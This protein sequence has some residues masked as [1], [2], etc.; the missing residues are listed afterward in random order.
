MLKELLKEK[1]IGEDDERRGE[2]QIQ[3]VTDRFIG[4]VEE[5]LAAKEADLLEI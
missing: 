1:E 5:M 3:K 4:K 2:D